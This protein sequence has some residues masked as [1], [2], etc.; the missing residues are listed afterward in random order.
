MKKFKFALMCAAALAL[1]ACGPDEPTNVCD[2]CGEDPCVCEEGSQ[3]TSPVSVTDGSLEEWNNL[4]AEY[5][6]TASLPE[7]AS[8]DGLKSL[9]VY[10]DEVYINIAVEYDPDVI[11][12]L[13]WPGFH[14]YLDTDNSAT[15]G[16]FG[17]QWSTAAF[18]IVLETGIFAEGQPNNY[19]PGVFYWW[20]EVGASGWEACDPALGEPS[21]ENKYGAIIVE[22]EGLIGTSQLVGNTFEIQLMWEKIPTAAPVPAPWANE[23]N[24]GVDIQQ[25]WQT[26]GLLPAAADDE[27]GVV[28]AAPLHVKFNK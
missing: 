10:A 26:A 4:P 13:S 27:N 18:D 14:V 20:G 16:G 9:K 5:V 6:A 23:F 21:A 7:G 3:Y 28:P 1:V 15:S 8:Y 11:T 17:G 2:V 12:D 25:N 24:L 19:D 22:G